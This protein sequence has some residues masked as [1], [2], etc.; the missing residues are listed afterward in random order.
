MNYIQFSIVIV[1]YKFKER[2]IF[3]KLSFLLYVDYL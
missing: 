3:I 1:I 2:K